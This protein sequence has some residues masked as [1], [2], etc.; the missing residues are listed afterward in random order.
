MRELE[1]AGSAADSTGRDDRAWR[2]YGFGLRVPEPLDPR[3]WNRCESQWAVASSSMR[4]LLLTVIYSGAN[5]QAPRIRESHV[6]PAY[7]VLHRPET[8]RGSIWFIFDDRAFA[9]ALGPLGYGHRV[10]HSLTMTAGLTARGMVSSATEV[11][12]KPGRGRRIAPRV[13][14][15]PLR[16]KPR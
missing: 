5:L 10:G 11:R 6:G 12:R 13:A 14:N 3:S 9:Q 7:L 2:V 8:R 16:K 15:P 1:E 4:G